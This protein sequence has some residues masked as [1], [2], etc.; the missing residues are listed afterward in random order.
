MK[1]RDFLSAFA[2][3]TAA[4]ALPYKAFAEM[5]SS[6][7]D[8]PPSDGTYW[9]NGAR[10]AISVS[11]QFEA[12]SQAATGA[13]S[14]FP[15]LDP[16][17]PD[18]PAT[19]WFEYGFKEGIPRLLDVWDRKKI[20]VTAHMVGKAVD[21]HPEL[22]KEIVDRGHEASAHGQTWSPQ[23]TLTPQEEKASYEANIASIY[24]ATGTKPVGFNAF[25]MRGSPHT[26]SILQ[27]LGMI[28][29]TDDISRD[30]PFIVD[31]NG[32]PFGVVPY[33]IHTNDIL[34]YELRYQSTLDFA[35][36]LKNEFD[37]LYSESGNRRRM[38]ALSAHDRVSGRPGRAKVIE[39]FITYA[40]QHKGVWFARKDEIMRYALGS[41]LTPRES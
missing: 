21:L 20:K 10:L 5:R 23:Y 31:V 6:G 29:H 33:A 18:Y 15:P 34:N 22:A 12:G 32:K 2:L 40:Q 24:K 9:P 11:M 16:K 41:P 14:P 8:Q 36:D 1:R 38:M 4:A 13:P 7:N 26:L 17:Y 19:K 27:E 25:F 35:Q 3:V 37:Q 30:E 39:D 28:Y